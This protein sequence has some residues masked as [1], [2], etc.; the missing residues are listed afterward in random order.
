[1]LIL[2]RG[3][4]PPNDWT[5]VVKN[6]SSKDRP[7]KAL[8]STGE[9]YRYGGNMNQYK[10]QRLRVYQLALKYIDMIYELSIGL[11]FEER[12][13]LR[14]QFTRAAASIALNIAEGSTGQSNKEQI[15]FIG[16][17]RRSLLETVACLDLIE[18]R[19]YFSKNSLVEI[20]RKGRDLFIKLSNFKNSLK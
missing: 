9:Y 3:Q 2:G 19:G 16:L 13:N 6:K 15:R 20:R 14:S 11:P 7:V 18:R 1:V 5:A 4:A 12:F 10:F 17:A 8:P